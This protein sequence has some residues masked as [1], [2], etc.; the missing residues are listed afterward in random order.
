MRRRCCTSCGMCR[1]TSE[2]PACD[3]IDLNCD[4]GEGFGQ[5]TL[6]DDAALLRLVTSANVA[7]GLHAGDPQTMRA[8]IERARQHGVAVGAHPA[9]PDLQGFGRR[10]MALDPREVEDVVLY[11]IGALDAFARAAGVRL[12]H[13]KPHGALYN[14]AA[15]DPATAEAIVRAVRSFDRDLILVGLAGS[16]LVA[17]GEVGGLR[18]AREAFADRAYEPDGSLRP[19]S[20]PG[21]VVHDRDAIARQALAI[22]RD[23]A[24]DTPSGRIAVDADTLCLHGDTPGSAMLAEMIARRL[25]EEGVS[26]KPLAEILRCR[27]APEHGHDGTSEAGRP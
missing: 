13:V 14:R 7:C 12:A 15:R 24:V 8:T 5:W 9:Y 17:A 23:R 22:A 16:V 10:E 6:G 3:M 19:R 27:S 25:N 26:I 18:V 2:L 11:Q 4:L 1:K 21:A 20:R